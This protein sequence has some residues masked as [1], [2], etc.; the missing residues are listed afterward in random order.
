VRIGQLILLSAALVCANP[1]DAQVYRWVDAEGN[2]H[3][4]DQAPPGIEAELVPIP[5]ERT[6]RAEA[7]QRLDELVST[8]EE[9]AATRREGSAQEAELDQRRAQ[10][11]RTCE[12]ARETLTQIENRRRI[13]VSGS[14]GTEFWTPEERQRRIAEAR[15]LI[16]ENCD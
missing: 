4:S 11:R 16:A 15:N 13:A 8:V 10:R 2:V 9:S 7:A 3:F 12:Q 14:G 1:V 5:V 6:D